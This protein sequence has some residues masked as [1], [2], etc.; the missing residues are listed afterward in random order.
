MGRRW[1]QLGPLRS[2]LVHSFVHGTLLEGEFFKAGSK[3]RHVVS[4][5]V[6]KVLFRLIIL[7]QPH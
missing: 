3:R 1:E 6:L 7:D 5:V 4:Q 2:V